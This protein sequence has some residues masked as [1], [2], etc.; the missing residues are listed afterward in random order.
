MTVAPGGVL[1]FGACG[2]RCPGEAAASCVAGAAAAADKKVS[3]ITCRQLCASLQFFDLSEG[4]EIPSVAPLSSLVNV[5]RLYLYDSTRVTD[6]D[7]S[8]IAG[9]PKLK[10]FRMQNRRGYSPSVKEI[11]EMIARRG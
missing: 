6:G 11:Q 2:Y 9:L 4:P 1:G 7:L 3:D 5:E 8:P 10:D